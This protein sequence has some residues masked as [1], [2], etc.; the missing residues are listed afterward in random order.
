MTRLKPLPSE[1]PERAHAKPI[2]RWVGGKRWLVPIVSD[3]AYA[4]LQ[5]TGG[6]Y[7]EP[8]LGGGAVAADLGLP[9]MLL[10][11][12]CEPL[13]NAFEQLCRNRDVVLWSLKNYR[14]RGTDADAYYKIR[15]EHP[16]GKVQRAA[17]FL[18]MNA[19]GFNGVYR[20]NSKGEYNVP[21]GSR[22]SQKPSF[23]TQTKADPFIAAIRSSELTAADFRQVIRRA[24]AGDFLFVDPPY[25]GVFSNYLKEGFSVGD[26]A[27][28]ADELQDA[29]K[30]GAAFVAANNDLPEVRKLYR[31]AHLTR[32]GELRRVNC[33]AKKRG[34]VACLLI[35]SHRNV[36]RQQ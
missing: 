16:Q 30:R 17:W 32:T 10:A 29:A 3:V 31:W 34:K 4:H 18:Y 35:T 14:R 27:A 9:N 20:E 24:G 22:K 21:H 11:D 12:L 6:R 19:T 36:L 7:I 13:I 28:L 1:L 15:A 5:S 2:V 25:Y 8:F 33:D 23:L 26:H